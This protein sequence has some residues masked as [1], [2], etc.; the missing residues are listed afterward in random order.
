MTWVLQLDDWDI[1]TSNA[2]ASRNSCIASLPDGVWP[3]VGGPGEKPIGKTF[4]PFRMRT[5]SA[6]TVTTDPVCARVAAVVRR[7]ARTVKT[8][9][10]WGKVRNFMLQKL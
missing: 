6:L 5:L 1:R 10:P 9:Q 2:P 8:R 3:L 7:R 4:R